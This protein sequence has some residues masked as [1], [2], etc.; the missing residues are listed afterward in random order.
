MKPEAE[1]PAPS[2]PPEIEVFFDGDCPLCTRE[3]NMICKKD[4][5]GRILFTNIAAQDFNASVR[6]FTQEQ[7]MD[8][9]HAELPDGTHIRGV[10]VFRR[11]Y[12][13][14]GFGPLVSMTRL[15]GVRQ[16]LDGIYKVWAKNRLRL[17]GRC[18]VS[19][20]GDEKTC[21]V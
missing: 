6:G 5:S 15:F 1:S 17:T 10:E 7:L 2:T 14:I 4:K 3:V 12:D 20:E 18:R 9:I 21:A 16:G 11:I 13:L 8:E 19:G